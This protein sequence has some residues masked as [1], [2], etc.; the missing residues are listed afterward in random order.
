MRTSFVVKPDR[1][2]RALDD[3]ETVACSPCQFDGPHG[4]IAGVAIFTLGTPRVVLDY[5]AA[6]KLALELVDTLDQLRSQG[7][8]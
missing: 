6:M 2:Q 7:A 8:T 4:P 1:V 5:P 3:S